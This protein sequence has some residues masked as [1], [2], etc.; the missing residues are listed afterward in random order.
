MG[1]VARISRIF[2]VY[3]LLLVQGSNA[4]TI[5]Q[6]SQR[7][8]HGASSRAISELRMAKDF[9]V[10]VDM[11]PSGSGL[12]AN[13]KFDTVLSSPGEIVEVRYKIP[14]GL[15]VAP[16]NNMAI[17]TKD[18]KGGEKVGDVLRY[19][20]HWTMGLPISDG[21]VDS[22]AAVAGGISW[23]CTMYNVMSAKGWD[24]V[25]EALVSNT[26]SRT[27]E[28]LLIFERPTKEE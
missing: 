14:F 6:L 11:P 2:L 16:K 19:T 7:Q 27:D 8:Q 21:L 28:V 12:R 17:C 25:V 13:L 23:Q 20:S 15:D 1:M 9:E 3:L 18:G 4:F 5:Q 24:D 10:V 22:A 26:P